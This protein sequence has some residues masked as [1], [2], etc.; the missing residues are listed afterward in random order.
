M[1]MV[2]AGGAINW[3]GRQVESSPILEPRIEPQLIQRERVSSEVDPVEPNADGDVA[4]GEP[5]TVGGGR[6][7]E[8]SPILEPRI[9][10]QLPR[11]KRVPSGGDPVEPNADGDVAGGEPSTVGG[12]VEGVV[13]QPR[14]TACKTCSIHLVVLIQFVGA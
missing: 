12:F 11:L 3:G 8:S 13:V 2:M 7:V 1:P 14:V 4:G 10:P 6:Q 9:E 5:S